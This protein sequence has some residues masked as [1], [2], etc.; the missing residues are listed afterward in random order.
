MATAAT[1]GATTIRSTTLGCSVGAPLTVEPSLGVFNEDAL[2]VIDYAIY[3]ASA[4]V[5]FAPPFPS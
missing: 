5:S 4:S 1:M 2:R 3:A